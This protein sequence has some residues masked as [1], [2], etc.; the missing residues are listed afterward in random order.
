MGE[1]RSKT[2][3]AVLTV[4][5]CVSVVIEPVS[6]IA[7]GVPDDG[8]RIF[9]SDDPDEQPDSPVDGAPSSDEI[10]T[11]EFARVGDVN[12]ATT[13]PEITVGET[14]LWEYRRQQ[15]N[16]IS[17]SR[18]TSVVFPH[19]PPRKN[20]GGWR[21]LITDAHITFMG[22]NG[23]AKP[24]LQNGNLVGGD[25]PLYVGE[26]GEILNYMDYRFRSSIANDRFS[27][28]CE[29]PVIDWGSTRIAGQLIE[30]ID[31]ASQICVDYLFP[32]EEERRV[33][34]D[35]EL[36]AEGDERVLS[37]SDLSLEGPATLRV[38][39]EITIKVVKEIDE[40]DWV[41]DSSPALSLDAGHFE[42]VDTREVIELSETIEVEHE[43]EIHVTD[44]EELSVHQTVIEQG[45]YNHVVLSFDGPDS[46]DR[47][48]RQDLRNRILLSS[49]DFGDERTV[50]T[51]WGAY[52]TRRYDAATRIDESGEANE[53]DAPNVLQMHLSGMR[54]NATIGGT[55]DH[56]GN[57]QVVGVEGLDTVPDTRPY[58]DN[59]NLSAR[60]PLVFTRVA[61]A[62]APNP[63]ESVTTI[64]GKEIPLDVDQRSEYRQP[65]VAFEG[66]GDGEVRITVTDPVTGD[67][68]SG[69]ELSIDGAEPGEAVT[70]GNGNVV[71]DLEGSLVAVTVP[72]DSLSN[73]GDVYYDRVTVS[74]TF[75]PAFALMEHTVRLVEWAV[76][77]SPLFLILFWIRSRDLLI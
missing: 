52:T 73:P 17:R 42:H 8:F 50:S 60:Q 29:D 63:A 20:S 56:G 12:Y 66:L 55:G 72:P 77:V 21:P 15:V 7:M 5:V 36:I 41:Q 18:T 62:E 44:D 30:T 70:D 25:Y 3:V 61:V 37:F 76:I 27:E 33:Y 54:R 35:G 31:D 24:H 38:E 46:G 48:T 64:H 11:S 23:G 22:V 19:S 69:K 10:S 74:E 53:F 39:G 4:L 71:V 34:V 16:E 26:S 68:I 59:V 49:I 75:L 6:A 40:F 67:P 2:L 32:T 1:S 65:N 28:G 58:E 14:N 13:D 43:R 47:I 9:Y 57:A 45:D 51:T